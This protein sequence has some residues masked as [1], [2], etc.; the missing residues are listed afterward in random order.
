MSY[1]KW[2]D[3]EIKIFSELNSN[4]CLLENEVSNNLENSTKKSIF[5]W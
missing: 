5:V 2:I 4:Y 3:L 1:L